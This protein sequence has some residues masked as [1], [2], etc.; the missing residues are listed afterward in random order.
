MS[1]KREKIQ[2]YYLHNTEVE[3]VFINEYMVDAKG[4]YVKVYLLALMHAELNMP[5]TNEAIAKQLSLSLEEVLSAWAYW[6]DRE[7]IRRHYQEGGD[8]LSYQVEI[9]NLKEQ[10]YEKNGKTKR[11]NGELRDSLPEHMNDQEL[12]KMYSRIEQATGR[13][14]DGKEPAAIL[15]WIRDLAITPELVVFAYEYCTEKRKNSKYN[16][17]ATVIKEWAGKGIKSVPEAEQYLSDTDNRHYLYKRVLKALGFHRNSTEEE[18]RIMDTWFD[19]LG[20]DLSKVL[21]ACNKTSGISN[22]NINYVNTILR[23]WSNEPKSAFA[24]GTGTGSNPISVALKSYETERAQNE[25]AAEARRQEVYRIVPRIREIEEELRAI[26]IAISKG[27]LSGDSQA[28]NE[29]KR[30]KSRLDTLNAEKSYLLTDHN[31]KIN[32][33]DT[34]YTCPLCKDTGLLDNGDRCSCF[35][36]KLAR[37]GKKV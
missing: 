31:F 1:F 35:V 18:K 5:I 37:S 7:V 34:W 33:M 21:I 14:F 22:P 27:M 19:E 30:N 11:T 8:H 15:E 3:N 36:D 24:E 9:R 23:A 6:E 29:I 20:F 16:Y 32:Y 28:K 4:D 12:R 17:V 2:N 25:A 26:G 13:L 10:I